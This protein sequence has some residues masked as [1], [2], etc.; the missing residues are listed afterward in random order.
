MIKKRLR[1]LIRVGLVEEAP[2]H[3]GRPV[4]EHPV[5]YANMRLIRVR[6]ELAFD[7]PVVEKWKWT[8]GEVDENLVEGD[9]D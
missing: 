1:W 9:D 6:Y 4:S 3:V 5:R 2:G 8:G 7:D